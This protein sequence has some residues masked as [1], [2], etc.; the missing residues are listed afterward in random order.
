M[1]YEKCVYATINYNILGLLIEE[2]TLMSYEEYIQQNILVPLGLSNTYLHKKE[3]S[4]NLTPGYKLRF[5]K[6]AKYDAPEYN[7]NKPAGYIMS[8]ASD[9]SK[10]LKWQ[11]NYE[12]SDSRFSTL[13]NIAHQIKSD[14]T[15]LVDNLFY[16]GGWIIDKD[17]D[18]ILHS[19][20]NPN[21][22]SFMVVDPKNKVGISVLANM[23]SSDT[24]HIALG[25]LD[26][27]NGKKPA[28]YSS[29]FNQLVDK[30]ASILIIIFII[31]LALLMFINLKL[32]K[33]I[34]KISDIK[35]T[36]PILLRIILSSLTA[37]ISIHC[38]VQLPLIFGMK[39]W[40]FIRV[41]YP[42]TAMF[43]VMLLAANILGV[44]ILFML[45]GF[46]RSKSKITNSNK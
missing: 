38:L 5:F 7:G 34:R 13:F 45:L 27:L 41:W 37:I 44:S 30:L 19:G 21:F 16:A 10:W 2:V 14:Q 11:L 46:T 12:K 28:G 39:N 1:P 32:A 25:I 29:D 40:D 4:T 17:K 26:I 35:I 3:V 20:S 9:I 22:S 8:S 31:L 6:P 33:K 43:A 24:T 36:S 18:L 23:K 15:P 42:Q